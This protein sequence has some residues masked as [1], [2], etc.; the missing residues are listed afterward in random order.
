MSIKQKILLVSTSYPSHRQDWR[1]VFIGHL[2]EA[3]AQ[4]ENLALSIWAPPG[5]YP[6]KSLACFNTS[7]C[8][9]LEKLMQQGGIAHLLRKSPVRFL[10][11]AWQLWQGL[12]RIYQ[13]SS[14]DVFH[15]NW[16]QNALPVPN[17]RK[18]LLISALGTDM[19]LLRK[20]LVIPWLRQVFKKHPTI[21]CPN[22]EWMIQPLEEAFGD[23]AKVHF[24]AFGIGQSWYDIVRQPLHDKPRWLVVSRLTKAKLGFLL[25]WCEKFFAGQPRELHLIGPMQEDIILPNWLYYH[26]SASPEVIQETWFP[27]VHGLISLS[28]HAEGRPQVMLEAMAAGLPIIASHLPAH[29]N[30]V[31]HQDTGWLCREQSDVE[32]GLLFFEHA[33][34]NHRAGLQAKQWVG[35]HIG[36]WTDCAGRYQEL[37]QELL[38]KNG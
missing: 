28:Q 12:R 26:G 18:P 25:T 35:K 14:A 37:Y 6:E 3:L 31:F 11:A 1:G 32:A 27:Q 9:F 38:S 20:P 2:A 7:E 16:L 13:Q 15:I 5:D 23:I 30:I 22:A 17:H 4:R 24:V 29:E 34:N 36:T 33:E 21:L 10:W 19:A 8:R